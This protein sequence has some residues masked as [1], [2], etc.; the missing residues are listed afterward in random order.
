MPWA[1]KDKTTPS[2]KPL[3]PMRFLPFTHLYNQF[4][5]FRPR[6]PKKIPQDLWMQ[7]QNLKQREDLNQSKSIHNLKHVCNLQHIHFIFIQRNKH[8]KGQQLAEEHLPKMQPLT[9]KLDSDYCFQDIFFFYYSCLGSEF[10][11]NS[12]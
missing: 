2:T 3:V 8:Y 1:L 7:Q 6:A 5:K 9:D 4:P 10:S 11:I 12:K